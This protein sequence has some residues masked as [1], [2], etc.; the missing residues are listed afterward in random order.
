MHTSPTTA[1]KL[2]VFLRE[3]PAVDSW[4]RMTAVCQETGEE[5]AGVG[6]AAAGELVA[7]VVVLSTTAVA[8]G[9]AVAGRT[10]ETVWAEGVARETAVLE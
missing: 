1:L 6:V 9:Q 7:T 10:A 5:E 8:V 2:D 3:S 4:K